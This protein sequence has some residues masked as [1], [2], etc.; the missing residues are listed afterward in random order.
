MDENQNNYIL[1]F[2]KQGS[3]YALSYCDIS[4]GELKPLKLKMKIH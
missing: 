1:S 3:N 4:T 2:I